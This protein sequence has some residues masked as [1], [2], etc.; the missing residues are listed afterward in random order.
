MRKKLTLLWLA[1]LLGCAS[2]TREYI[3]AEQVSE[4]TS[5]PKDDIRIISISPDHVRA[6]VN[7]CGTLRQYQDLATYVGVDIH[8]RY[9]EIH[10]SKPCVETQV[11]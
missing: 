3:L 7:A 9:E 11:K 2:L 5:C 10:A 1:L 4:M 6:Q 8:P